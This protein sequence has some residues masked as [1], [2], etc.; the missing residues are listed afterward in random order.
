MSEKRRAQA[1]DFIEAGNRAAVMQLGEVIP[2]LRVMCDRLMVDDASYCL[3]C[4]PGQYAT[5]HE[6]DCPYSKALDILAGYDDDAAVA[7]LEGAGVESAADARKRHG[8]APLSEEQ[9]EANLQANLDDLEQSGEGG[10]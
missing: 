6:A 1:S 9:Q 7:A 5:A 8:F 2:I 3:V 4:D 10:K